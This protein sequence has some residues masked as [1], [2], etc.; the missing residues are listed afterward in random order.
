M[1]VFGRL[2][3]FHRDRKAVIQK[4]QQLSDEEFKKQYRLDRLTF[5]WLLALI[6]PRIKSDAIKAICSSGQPVQPIVKL[7]AALRYLAGG[8]YLDIAFGYSIFYKNVMHFVWQVLTAIDDTLDNINFPIEDE[9]RLRDLERGF[10]NLCGGVF[11]GTVAACDG[12]VFQMQKP[13]A[14]AVDNDVASLFTRKGYYA[15]GQNLL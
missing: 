1:K 15:F 4:I 10:S 9:E 5:D 2:G 7:A 3:N 6:E 8:I 13:P 11:P 14:D 12:V